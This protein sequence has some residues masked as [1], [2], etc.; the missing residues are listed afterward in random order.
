ME[1]KVSVIMTVK[2]FK[3]YLRESIDSILD[4]TFEDFEFVIID[5]HSTDGTSEL[6]D[7]YDDA[8][9][10]HIL[11]KDDR[12]FTFSRSLNHALDHAAAPYIARHDA[13]DISLPQRLERQYTFLTEHPDI[14]VVGTYLDM[15]DVDLNP[16][17]TLIHPVAHDEIVKQLRFSP[18]IAHAT[19]M[20]KR[21]VFERY[22][23]NEIMKDSE[24][25]E[26]WLRIV[27]DKSFRFH[28]I[29][30]SLYK[31]RRYG[32]NLSEERVIQKFVYS[33]YARRHVLGKPSQR[34]TPEEIEERLKKSF[35]RERRRY[36]SQLNMEVFYNTPPYS[37]RKYYALLVSAFLFPQFWLN[38]VVK[39]VRFHRT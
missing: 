18:S 39:K 9:I 7:S 23:Y 28:N 10:R 34:L 21:A 24:D 36:L 38:E 6:I 37:A 30:E 22:R 32:W 2:N 35:T 16:M 19:I 20:A 14:D 29:P 5:Y 4:Q 15:V 33:T 25:Y 31:Y 3:T 11:L 17:S 1:P 26:L 27:R 12:P 13:D 8:R